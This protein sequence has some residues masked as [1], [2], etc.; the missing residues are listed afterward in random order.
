MAGQFF[1]ACAL[2]HHPPHLQRAL[3]LQPHQPALVFHCFAKVLAERGQPLLAAQLI[4]RCRQGNSCDVMH[5]FERVEVRNGITVR[6]CL[7]WC[8]QVILKRAFQGRG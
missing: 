5:P 2:P 8:Q 6:P 3:A 1:A 4:K 7:V